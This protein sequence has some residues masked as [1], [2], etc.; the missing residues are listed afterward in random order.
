VLEREFYAGAFMRS[1]ISKKR[2]TVCFIRYIDD[3]LTT[4]LD[5]IV[6][7]MCQGFLATIEGFDA[8]IIHIALDRE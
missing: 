1:S 2:S 5:S 8:E 6:P 3:N 4:V 7:P